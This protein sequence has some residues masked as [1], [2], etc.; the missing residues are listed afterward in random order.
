MPIWQLTEVLRG[1]ICHIHII[2]IMQCLNI[3][4]NS[5]VFAFLALLAYGL[6]RRDPQTIYKMGMNFYCFVGVKFFHL[7]KKVAEPL[8]C[9]LAAL[10]ECIWR[11]SCP[12][13]EG[14][15]GSGNA[16]QRVPYDFDAHSK[17]SSCDLKSCNNYRLNLNFN[18]NNLLQAVTL[19]NT[20]LWIKFRN[21]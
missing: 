19:K 16:S 3:N 10:H 11:T 4:H 8:Q 20:V 14:T 6:V 15:V 18:A 17:H 2:H 12:P 7:E 5:F 13:I 9:A 21:S 1:F